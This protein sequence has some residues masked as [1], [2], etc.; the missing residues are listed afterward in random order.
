M[1]TALQEARRGHSRAFED[2]V[3]EHQAMVFSIGWHFLADRGLAEDLSQEVFLQLHQNLAAIESA[4]HLTHW[5]RRVAA[6][7]CIDFSRRKYFRRESPLEETHEVG[8]ESSLP[9]S[10]LSDRLRQS[11]AQLPDKQR[12][13]VV[14]RYQEELELHEIAELLDIPLN[15]VKSTL[16]RA[17]E[18]LRGKLARKLKEA[19]YA[20]L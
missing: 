13:A 11:V 18:N 10:F 6:H 20:F 17:I 9:D 19:R 15:T 7:R 1:D 3:R 12:I 5:L 4:S 8:K 16:H 2:I 14:L